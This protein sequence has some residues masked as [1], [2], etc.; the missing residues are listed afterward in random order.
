MKLTLSAGARLT[1]ASITKG[2]QFYLQYLEKDM[3][4]RW[5]F[6]CENNAL[7]KI[8]WAVMNKDMNM[9]DHRTVL[10]KNPKITVCYQIWD[11]QGQEKVA[12]WA[13]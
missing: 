8:L 1:W 12:F 6:Y 2:K 9:I 10:T 11:D 5:K 13:R 4:V 3:T 7:S